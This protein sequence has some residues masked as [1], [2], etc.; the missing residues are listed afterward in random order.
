LTLGDDRLPYGLWKAIEHMR[1]GEKALVMI[2][3]KYGYA[4]EKN[5]ETV[6]IPRGW[7]EDEKK[8]ELMTRRV[9]FEITLHDWVVRHDI[10]GDK[11][12]VKQV[13]RKG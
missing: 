1:K 2:K 9:F 8:K 4:C 11:L 7:T 13:H 10:N 6:L 12:L 5:K 3:P